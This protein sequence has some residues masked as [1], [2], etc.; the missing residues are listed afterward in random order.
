MDYTVSLSVRVRA[1]CY[2]CAASPAAVQQKP[3]LFFPCIALYSLDPEIRLG[4]PLLL[5][6]GNLEP[7]TS[8]CL[9]SA[10]Y[11]SHWA[12]SLTTA[13]YRP[14]YR[15]STDPQ[16][17]QLAA[18]TIAITLILVFLLPATRP[19]LSWTPDDT[20]RIAFAPSRRMISNPVQLVSSRTRKEGPVRK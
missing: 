18:R 3:G 19:L 14:F 10:F 4:P 9:Y 8:F 20:T 12:N 11:S 5:F 1:L 7:P 2:T 15:P 16:D 13:L 6:L 17:D